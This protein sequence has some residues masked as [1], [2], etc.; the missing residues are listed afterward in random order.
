LGFETS[1]TQKSPSS[2]DFSVPFGILF[3]NE[4]I[5]FDNVDLAIDSAERLATTDRTTALRA[6]LT[7]FIS[8]YS[9][10]LCKRESVPSIV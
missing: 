5:A 4:F 3:G 8:F 6:F 2:V 7:G 1:A 10:A 9:L